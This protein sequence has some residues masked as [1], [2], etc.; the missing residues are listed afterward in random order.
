MSIS[1]GIDPAQRERVRQSVATAKSVFS[2]TSLV[3][4]SPDC[5]TLELVIRANDEGR[6]AISN[7][8]VERRMQNFVQL[9]QK[10]AAGNLVLILF[11]TTMGVYATMLL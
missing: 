3:P 8:L 11:F 2:I 4:H 5:D 10:R 7:L 1:W 6:R 9:L